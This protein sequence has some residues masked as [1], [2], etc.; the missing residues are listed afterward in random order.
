MLFACSVISEDGWG[1][2]MSFSWS[3]QFF[4]FHKSDI[5]Y[6]TNDPSVQADKIVLD[7]T[8]TT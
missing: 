1:L 4:N 7:Y 5:L 2:D 3:W 6:G 8:Q